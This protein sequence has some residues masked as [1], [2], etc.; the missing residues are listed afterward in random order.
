MPG[1]SLCLPLYLWCLVSQEEAERLY[2]SCGRYD[3]LNKFYQACGQWQ[4]AIEM[5]ETHD[6]VHLRTTYYSYAKHQ[7]ATGENIVA[8]S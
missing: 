8:I 4:R 5:A 7:E 3:L 1:L 2:R 6:R